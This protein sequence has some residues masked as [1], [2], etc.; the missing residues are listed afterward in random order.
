MNTNSTIRSA[1]ESL[2]GLNAGATRA[3][4]VSDLADH[5]KVGLKG[6]GVSDWLQ[7]RQM[8]CPADVYDVVRVDDGSLAVRV[9]SD[10]VILESPDSGEL[11]E[12]VE[13]ALKARVPGV[14]RVEQQTSTFRL[15][16]P[17]AIPVWA[18]TCGVD[19]PAEP[20]DRILYT[21]VAGISCG[22][23]PEII[24]GERAYRIWVDYS[25]APDFFRTIIEITRGLRRNVAP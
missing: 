22:I 2:A 24:N 12:T 7:E 19:V 11:V 14:Y 9:G 3:V 13:V 16:G 8:A 4:S 18:Q 5:R 17:A 1:V 25:Y 10:E 23:I 6:P 20:L 15:S 21:R